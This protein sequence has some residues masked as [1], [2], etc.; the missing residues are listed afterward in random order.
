MNFIIYLIRTEK[1]IKEIRLQRS[2]CA[3][4]LSK[5]NL[6]WKSEFFLP[7]L[8]H[9]PLLANSSYLSQQADRNGRR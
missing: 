3:G 5:V 2:Y 4:I 1:Q 7:G 8:E 9:R 6:P